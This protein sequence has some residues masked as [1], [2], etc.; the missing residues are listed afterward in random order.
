MINFPK[1][2][3]SYKIALISCGGTIAMSQ[4]NDGTLIPELNARQLVKSS[5]MLANFGSKLSIIDLF[6]KDSTNI[7]R[8]DWQA[9]VNK[10][11]EVYAKY[12]GIIITHGTDTMANT[13]TAVSLAFGSALSIPIIFTGSQLPMMVSGTDARVNLERSAKVLLEAMRQHVAEVLIVFS[14][15]VLRASR[16]L[17]T[18]E[19]RFDAFDSPAFPHIADITAADEIIFSPN[20]VISSKTKSTITPV[21]TF[22]GGVFAV[23]TDADVDPELILNISMSKKCKALILKSLGSGNVPASGDN[24]LL[25]VIKQ[26]LEA[27]KPVIL[28]SKFVGGKTIPE[29]YEP[30]KA[31][32][33]AGAGHAGNM[34]DVAAKVKLMWLIGRGITS[35]AAVSKAML[36]PVVGELD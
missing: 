8:H 21:N 23:E 13:A 2:K 6:N 31:A 27:G 12:D 32:L 29:M 26:T 15:R 3:T 24:S 30:G 19:S 1:N 16:A 11:T 25:P 36:K 35:P 22:D 14:D 18:S 33:E 17:K 10:I 5:P 9:L 34:T 20:T 4:R 7:D 28:T